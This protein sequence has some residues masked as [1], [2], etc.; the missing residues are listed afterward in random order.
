[1]ARR[2]KQGWGVTIVFTGLTAYFAAHAFTGQQGIHEWS[3]AR[4][5]IAALQKD[6]NELTIHRAK[7]EERIARLRDESD[8]DLDYLEERARALAGV[9]H[10]LDILV[11]LGAY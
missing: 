3:S 11:P 8:L 1:M 6:M 7:L 10:P 4:H 9:A 2:R 5:R